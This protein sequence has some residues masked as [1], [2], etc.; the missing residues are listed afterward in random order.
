[1]QYLKEPDYKWIARLRGTLWRQW[2]GTELAQTVVWEP[3]RGT[4]QRTVFSY[5]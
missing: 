4:I 5:Y 1:M 2:E 3:V